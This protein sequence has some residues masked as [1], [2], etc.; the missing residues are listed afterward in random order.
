MRT[1]AAIALGLVAL[2][3]AVFLQVRRHEFVDFDDV[4]DIAGN[5]DLDASSPADA[6]RLAFTKTLTGNWIPLTMLSLQADHALHGGA[7]SGYL[8]TNVGLHALA[9]IVLFLALARMTGSTLRSAFVAAVFAVHPLHVESVAWVSERKDVLS[10]LFWMLTLAAYAHFAARPGTGRYALVLLAFGLGLLAKPMLVTLPC[11]LLLLDHWPLARL[12]RRAWLEKLPMLALSAA[13]AG[14]T[15]WV[16]REQGAA[17]FGEALPLGQ[18]LANALDSYVT[19][20]RQTLWPT[21]LA[22][23]Y[24]HPQASLSALRIAADAVALGVASGVAVGLRRSKP[25]LLVGWLWF[26]GTLVPVIG[27]VQVGYQARADRYMYIPQV[28]LTIA[29]V[30]CVSDLARPRAARRALAA[31]AA[32]VLA[33][34]SAAAWVQVGYWRDSVTLLEHALAVAPGGVPVHTQLANV[35]LRAERYDLAEH[36]YRQAYRLSA[37]TGVSP[38]T[39]RPNLARFQLAMGE[40]F[41][42]R[43]DP[44][45]AARRYAEVLSLYPEDGRARTRLIGALVSAGRDAEARSQLE[46]ALRETPNDAR[47]HALLGFVALSERR[48]P[49]ALAQSREAV[50]LAPD[51]VSARNNLAWILATAP[52]PSLRDPDEALRLAEELAAHSRAPLADHLDTLAAAQAA[53]GDPEEAARTAER[54]LAA[55][56]QAQSAELARAIRARLARYRAGAAWVDPA[57]SE[58][59]PTRER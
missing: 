44:A 53:A 49:E 1:R 5:A 24:P 36:H 10:G 16:Q 6:L 41:E 9:S 13:A 8:I 43:G 37:E 18:R 27:L 25:Y 34:L 33:A 29:L 47:L 35:H 59:D 58:S 3:L 51:L 11:V 52:D 39:T 22:V 32:T 50:R 45:A 17:A 7:P 20:V 23:F 26:L 19:Y 48:Y 42:K 2:T 12:G 28:G 14:V 54:A 46:H 31:A 40:D 21:D 4:S 57:P 15:L 55:A 30:W 38:E 56:E